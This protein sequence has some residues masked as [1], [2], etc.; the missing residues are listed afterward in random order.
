METLNILRQSIAHQSGTTLFLAGIDVL[1]A[2]LF[3]K[4]FSMFNDVCT[5]VA[6]FGEGDI[7]LSLLDLEITSFQRSAELVHLVA[8]IVDVEFT[9]HLVAGR[10]QH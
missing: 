3:G 9:L 7:F 6:V 2:M 10:V 5:L 8:S 1:V 4:V